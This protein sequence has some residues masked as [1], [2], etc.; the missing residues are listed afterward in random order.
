MLLPKQNAVE[1]IMHAGTYEEAYLTQHF[2]L[3]Q[4]QLTQALLPQAL[5]PQASF[6]SPCLRVGG[7]KWCI[8]VPVFG[9]K[10]F[11]VPKIGTWKACCA[12]KFGWPPLSCGI[13]RC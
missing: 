4:A 2:L 11:T 3:T 6:C 13:S 7:G 1:R 8:N 5:H 9:R 10:C 12:T